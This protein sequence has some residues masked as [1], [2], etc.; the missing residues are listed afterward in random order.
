MNGDSIHMPA[1]GDYPKYTLFCGFVIRIVGPD[2]APEYLV[3]D[4]WQAEPPAED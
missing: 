2:D 3:D 4:E 1:T